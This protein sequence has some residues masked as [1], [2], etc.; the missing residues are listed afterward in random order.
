MLEDQDSDAYEEL[1]EDDSCWAENEQCREFDGSWEGNKQCREDIDSPDD[2]NGKSQQSSVLK[3][4]I[5]QM[6]FDPVQQ[7]WISCHQKTREEQTE[8]DVFWGLDN[9]L[10]S[11]VDT[12]DAKDWP[13][14]FHIS[15]ALEAEW[16]Q[17]EKAHQLEP[18]AWR[19]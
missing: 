10:V 16:R 4:F 7:S 11:P 13:S 19:K 9:E 8:E 6:K 12:S 15:E 3:S 14:A 2:K 18:Q 5:G 1:D 17:S